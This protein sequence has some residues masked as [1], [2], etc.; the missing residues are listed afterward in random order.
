MGVEREE[1]TMN[2]IWCL[3]VGLLLA[4]ASMPSLVT[5]QGVQSVG[6]WEPP[7]VWPTVAIHAALLPTGEV[8]HYGKAPPGLGSEAM[9]WDPV[10]DVF[11]NVDADA[12]LFCSGLSF[13]PDG[14]LYITGGNDG[15]AC[16][17]QGIPDTHRFDP[18]SLSWTKLQDMA[19]ARWYPSNLTLGTGDVLILSGFDEL[20]QL[21]PLMERYTPGGALKLVSGGS[22]LLQSYPWMHL[23]SS[24]RVAH[25]GP[26]AQTR[27]FD[28]DL[29]GWQTVTTTGFGGKR[30]H[31]TSVRVPRR[32]D[33]IMIIGG[34]LQGSPTDSCERIDFQQASPAW[35]ATGSLAHARFHAAN[36]VLLPDGKVMLVG[37]GAGGKYGS[38]VL[39]PELYDPDTE[40]WS[41]LPPHVYGRMYHSTALLLPDGRVLLAGQDD[42]P[43]EFTAEIYHPAYLLRGSR[44]VIDAAPKMIHYGRSFWVRSEQAQDI[45]SVVLMRLS[46]VTHSWDTGQLHVDLTFSATAP[47]RLRIQAPPTSVTTP[48]GYYMLFLLTDDG[49]PSVARMLQLLPEPPFGAKPSRPKK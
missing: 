28:P 44:P 48:P 49:V 8:L 18:L 37:G 30:D 17:L 5:A 34:R 25:V 10:A 12:D 29:P 22:L 15:S 2:R 32:T 31:G 47:D 23:L 16:V 7:R 1:Q 27:S 4:C 40:G 43:G 6:V 21:T 26:E 20:C 35:Q 3:G 45:A 39:I 36:A 46:T 19:V 42:G 41:P 13:L 38:P 9:L 11:M 24:G 33:Q 14:K